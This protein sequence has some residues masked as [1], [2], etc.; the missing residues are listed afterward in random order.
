M[1]ADI[2]DHKSKEVVIKG[3]SRELTKTLTTSFVI[4]RIIRYP[5]M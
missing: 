1:I 2:Y 5:I 3:S 4:N